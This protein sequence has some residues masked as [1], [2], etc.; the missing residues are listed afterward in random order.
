[1]INTLLQTRVEDV[2][3]GRIM[4]LYTLSFFGFAPFGNLAIGVVA[5]KFGL[6]LT[7]GVSALLALLLSRLIVQKFPLVAKLP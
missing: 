5:E 4:G 1:L 7:I 6:S 3:R 2:Y